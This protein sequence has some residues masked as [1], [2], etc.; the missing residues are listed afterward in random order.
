MLAMQAKDVA[1][2][3][4]LLLVASLGNTLGACVNYTLGYFAARM[5][6]H[7]WFPATLKQLERA[8]RWYAKWGIWSLLLS[9]VPFIGDPLTVIAGLLRTPFWKFLIMVAMAKSGRYAALMWLAY[10]W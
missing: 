1:P 8:E 3:V 9:W 6:E 4:T 7:A 2:A 5:R 10:C